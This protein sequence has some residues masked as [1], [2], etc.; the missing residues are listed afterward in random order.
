MINL[1]LAILSGVLLVLAFPK[2]SIYM[3]AYVALIPLFFAIKR[4]RSKPAAFFYG[5]IS[6][7]ILF[8][9]S[10]YWVTVLS[11]WADWWAY[12]AWAGLVLAESVF[13][14]VFALIYKLLL[15]KYPKYDLLFVPF[16][17]VLIDAVR[18]LGPYGVTGGVLAYSQADN[19]I[20][21]QT[22]RL[23][24][25]YGLSFFIVLINI[26]LLKAVLEK[27]IKP[28]IPAVII[29]LIVALYGGLRVKNYHDSGKMLRVSVVQ[30]N[31]PQ[32]VKMDFG[33]TYNIVETHDLMSKKAALYKPDVIIWPETAVPIY[34]FE[35]RSILGSI[36][37]TIKSCGA[38]FLIGTPYREGD[39]IY[40]S[41]AGFSPSGEVVGRYDKRRLVPFGEYLPLRPI[42]FHLLGDNPMFVE[43]YNANPKQ[44]VIDIAGT[45]AGVV[46]CF[47]STLPYI[48]RDVVKKG[49][50]F[51]VVATNDAWFFDTAAIYEHVQAAKMR[52]VE[53]D[54]YVVQAANTG[55]SAI[56]DPLGR[57]KNSTNVNDSAVL[58]GEIFVH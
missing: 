54:M 52:A 6:G 25:S 37:D 23:V 28:L 27:N 2:F 1:G 44:Q 13:V 11:K 49:A 21:L 58:N 55:I 26:A 22:A 50:K 19:L 38:Y 30:A 3:L 32:D 24:T 5:F 53:N 43:D 34:L 40:N 41:V 16:L 4:A 42:F 47:E 15:G 7:M 10:L 36:K 18:A 57:V 9:G 35:T 12:L 20:V 8:G 56:I 17:W 51:L 31:V 39:K 33:F 14:A 45:K 48:V 46:I 29:A